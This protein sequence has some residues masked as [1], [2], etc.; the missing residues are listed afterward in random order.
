MT[1]DPLARLD[2]I[3]G[4]LNKIASDEDDAR[5]KGRQPGGGD[6]GSK[7]AN[8]ASGAKTS[9]LKA[10]VGYETGSYTDNNKVS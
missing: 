4:S 1:A 3:L 5:T 8:K 7:K 10:G 6:S 2:E 9:T